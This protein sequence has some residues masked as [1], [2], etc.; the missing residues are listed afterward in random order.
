MKIYILAGWMITNLFKKYLFYPFMWR[1]TKV[2]SELWSQHHIQNRTP[3]KN[4]S[5][6]QS[7]KIKYDD[8][9]LCRVIQSLINQK[10]YTVKHVVL[11][12]RSDRQKS[13]GKVLKCATGWS[14]CSIRVSLIA[15]TSEKWVWLWQ[16][17]RK[18]NEPYMYRWTF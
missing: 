18:L 16:A 4:I 14:K 17:F 3:R 13:L 10:L 12:E 1:H 2:L 6:Y 9:I 8:I 11:S 7:H 15:Y 5:R